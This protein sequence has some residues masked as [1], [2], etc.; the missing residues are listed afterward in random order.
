MP[1]YRMLIILCA[2]IFASNKNC[3]PEDESKIS[4]PIMNFSKTV[5]KVLAHTLIV[6]IV[7]FF[8]GILVANK[9]LGL[10]I[11][12]LVSMICYAISVLLFRQQIVIYLIHLYQ[13]KAPTN[14]R[15]KCVHTPSCSEYMI[16]SIEKYGLIKGVSK[17]ID[18][19]RRCG[20]PALTDYP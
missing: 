18:R 8:A 13:L 2:Y 9:E 4:R 19:L 6:S 11:I 7:C 15:A 1:A 16:L 14:I 17:G 5:I 12:M 10:G 20:P 3:S